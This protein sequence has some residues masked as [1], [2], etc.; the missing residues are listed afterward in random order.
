MTSARL[1]ESIAGF[2]LASLVRLG[3]WNAFELARVAAGSPPG[4]G[5]AA[6]AA[7]VAAY[8]RDVARIAVDAVRTAADPS[9]FNRAD[10]VKT[11][12][13]WWG[14]P[15]W[16][17]AGPRADLAVVKSLF[18]LM[19]D[20]GVE[21]ESGAAGEREAAAMAAALDA[22]FPSLLPKYFAAASRGGAL[23][24]GAQ[25][26]ARQV[27]RGALYARDAEFRRAFEAMY[28]DAV[29]RGAHMQ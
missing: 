17:R 5:D 23:P 4:P 13:E 28:A 27:R 16:D 14:S 2:D 3:S 29:S 10:F 1:A 11:V 21:A 7:V 26:V 20:A 12:F 24:P 22:R 6:A 9:P 19:R 8:S 18:R 25:A 15:P